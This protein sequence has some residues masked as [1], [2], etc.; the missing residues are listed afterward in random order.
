MFISL[1]FFPHDSFEV[2]VRTASH[3]FINSGVVTLLMVPMSEEKS[4][5]PWVLWPFVALWRLVSGIFKLV[6]RVVAITLGIILLLVGV[7][8]C[9]TVI[10]LVVGIP[11]VIFGLLLILRGLF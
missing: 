9:L 3:A 8:L 10:G 11:M 5:T 4:K 2:V 6:G 7:V 1:L